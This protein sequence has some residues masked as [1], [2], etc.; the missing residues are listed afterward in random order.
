[1]RTHERWLMAAAA[2]ALLTLFFA[3]LRCDLAARSESEAAAPHAGRS[4]TFGLVAD[5]EAIAAASPRTERADA[6]RPDVPPH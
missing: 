3:L 1:M 2:G 4:T 6:E 5:T